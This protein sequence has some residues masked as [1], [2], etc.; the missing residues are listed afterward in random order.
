M[1]KEELNMCSHLAVPPPPPKKKNLAG[2]C[3]ELPA[4]L[5][6]AT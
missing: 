6:G 3:V 1:Q 2:T 4:K 5:H